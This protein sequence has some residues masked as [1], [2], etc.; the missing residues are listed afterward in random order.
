M[1]DDFNAE[2]EKQKMK[3]IMEVPPDKNGVRSIGPEIAERI[4][5]R[6]KP[7]E[8]EYRSK[9]QDQSNEFDRHYQRET[10]RQEQ[11]G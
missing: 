11:V 3:F 6:M 2:L 5:E 1:R 10:E 9:F 4:E 8:E 7:L